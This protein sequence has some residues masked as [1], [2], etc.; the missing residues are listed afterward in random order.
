MEFKVGDRIEMLEDCRPLNKGEI[1]TVSKR[2]DGTLEVRDNLKGDGAYC[3]HM[4]SKWKL[5]DSTGILNIKMSKTKKVYSVLVVNKK[6]SKEEKTSSTVVADNEQ[7][8]TLKAFGVDVDNLFI[9]VEEIGEYQEEKPIEVVNVDGK[10][11]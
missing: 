8:A 4:N 7:Q 10:N 6:T 5:I 9:K 1:Y 3:S 11:K 2:G